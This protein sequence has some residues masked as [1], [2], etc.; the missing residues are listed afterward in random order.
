MPE[1]FR[2]SREHEWA[3]DN[4][5]GTVTIGVSHYAQDALGDIVF[6]ELPGLGDTFDAEQEFG[7]VESVKTV[8][9]VYAPVAGEIV[10]VN[11]ELEDAPELVNESPYEG[12]WLVRIKMND[13][14]DLDGL[15]DAESYEEF[16]S[17]SE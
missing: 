14:D 15:M 10:A 11:D 17:E 9:D 16:L 12:G 1:G 4:G 7:V 2:F 5:D 8:S 3:H 6:V 13:P